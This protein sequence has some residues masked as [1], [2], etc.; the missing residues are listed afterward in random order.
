[1]LFP[2]HGRRW[3]CSQPV[4]VRFPPRKCRLK[5]ASCGC[6][7]RDNILELEWPALLSTCTERLE[8]V[9]DQQYAI[10]ANV[11]YFASSFICIKNNLTVYFVQA[12]LPCLLAESNLGPLSPATL[13]GIQAENGCSVTSDPPGVGV[14]KSDHHEDMEP[15]ARQSGRCP[16]ETT[17][18]MKLGG[19][20]L[21]QLKRAQPRA[22]AK[23]SSKFHRTQT[24]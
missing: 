16:N 21:L 20:Q 15:L 17:T 9:M 11:P 22:V 4:P 3:C 7:W 5:A 2:R 23:N 6:L 14:Q 10:D 19:S 1:M 13:A 12:R 18:P 24:A 8:H